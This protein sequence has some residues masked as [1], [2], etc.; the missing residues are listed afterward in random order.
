MS[1]FA[2]MVDFFLG[3]DNDV[4]VATPD[5]YME[6]EACFPSED[7][8][9]TNSRSSSPSKRPQTQAHL[10]QELDETISLRSQKMAETHDRLDRISRDLDEKIKKKNGG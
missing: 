5:T 8:T 6:P 3:R 10:K 9:A 2:K 4:K 1:F 7:T